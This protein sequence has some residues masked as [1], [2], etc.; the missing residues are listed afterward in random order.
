MSSKKITVRNRN[1][2]RNH[3]ESMLPPTQDRRPSTMS[4]N[5]VINSSFRKI[6]QIR[7]QDLVSECVSMFDCITENHIKKRKT[8]FLHKYSS[9][10]NELCSLFTINTDKQLS[11]L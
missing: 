10:S 9:S 5:Y 6:F 11:A 4:F 7:S 1:R 3:T 8:K 2:N